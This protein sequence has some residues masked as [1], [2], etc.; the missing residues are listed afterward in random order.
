MISYIVASNND[1]VLDANLRATLELVGD[2]ELVVVEDPPSIAVAYN[3]GQAQARNPIRCYVHSDVQFRDPAGLRAGLIQHCTNAVGM[4]GLIGSFDRALPWWEA[5]E[6]RGAVVDVRMG[7][8]AFARTGPCSYLDGLLLATAHELTWD[9][10]YPGFHMY[11]H[12]ICEQMLAR[13][14]S[15]YC[16]PGGPAVLH[17]T[18]N[19]SDVAKLNGWDAAVNRFRDKWGTA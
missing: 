15:N 19:P 11:D 7:L 8:L 10:S 6:G 9:E 12:D 3:K 17:N 18:R 16:M 1:E 13:G 2:D 14:L 5:R 4:V